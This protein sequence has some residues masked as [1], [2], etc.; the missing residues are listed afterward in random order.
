[1]QTDNADAQCDKLATDLSWQR[2]AS[3]VSNFQLPHLHLTYPTCTLGWVI[4]PAKTVPEMTYNVFSGT[5]NPTH[6]LTHCIWRLRREWLR[7]S[8]AEIFGIRKL[9]PWIILWRCLRDP[10][11]S[12]FSRTPTC[13][14]QTDKR[15]DRH[16]TTANIRANYLRADKNCCH[17]LEIFAEKSPNSCETFN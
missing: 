2:F 5:L 17:I 1:M 13:D 9:G 7:L 8:F 14:R 12:R 15:T 10:T 4:W 11:F 3:K 6:S 16:T